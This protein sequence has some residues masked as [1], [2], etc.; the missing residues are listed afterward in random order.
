MSLANI[1]FLL[2]AKCAV[3]AAHAGVPIGTHVLARSEA[4]I[5]EVGGVS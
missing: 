2:K 5:T 4:R 1:F 3:I